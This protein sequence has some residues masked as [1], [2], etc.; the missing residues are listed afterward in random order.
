M[1]YKRLMAQVEIAAANEWHDAMVWRNEARERNCRADVEY[2]N[3][4]M[5]GMK[6]MAEMLGFEIELDAN[7]YMI[8]ILRKND[9]T[10]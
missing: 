9:T 7:G 8:E 10:L 6:M 4:Y 2:Y 3:G 5:Q 1:A